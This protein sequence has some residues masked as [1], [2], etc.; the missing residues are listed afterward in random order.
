MSYFLTGSLGISEVKCIVLCL[1]L[2]MMQ[3]FIGGG[4]YRREWR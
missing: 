4:L 2:E 3:P 1:S